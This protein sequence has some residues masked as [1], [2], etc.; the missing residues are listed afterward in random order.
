MTARNSEGYESPVGTAADAVV[1]T[2]IEDRLAV[3]LVRRADPPARGQLA[4]PGGFVGS[5]ETSEQTIAR[6]L[7]EKTGL[8]SVYTE[9]LRTYDDPGRD[10][11]GWLPAVAYLALVPS[12]LLPPDSDALWMP[13]AELPELPFDHNEM[14]AYGLERL[15]SKLLTSNIAAGL[16]PERFTISEARRVFEVL[17][18]RS[19]HAGN[20][21]RDFKASGLARPT[22]EHRRAGRGRPAELWEYTSREQTWRW[23]GEAEMHT[24]LT[25]QPVL[26]REL[27]YRHQP[28]VEVR[29]EN[30]HSRLDLVADQVVSTCRLLGSAADIRSLADNLDRL[31][32]DGAPWTGN[33]IVGQ[34]ATPALVAAGAGDSRIRVWQLDR[35]QQTLRCAS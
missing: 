25:K 19:W 20:F 11:R 26:W 28:V 8:P 12:T 3:L 29:S 7:S 31:Q 16:L 32:G 23:Y 22:A 13:L 1:F 35:D 4:L 27:G 15:M 6:K 33:L 34:P 18:G 21:T 10:P 17:S 14:I 24:L 2:I 5:T 9:Q 30:G